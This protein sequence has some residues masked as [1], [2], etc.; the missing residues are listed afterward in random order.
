MFIINRYAGQRI[1]IGGVE[2]KIHRI[3]SDRVW[4]AIP[5]GLDVVKWPPK[6]QDIVDRD[7][8]RIEYGRKRQAP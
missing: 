2:I 1:T 3:Q 5:S 7:D 4:L 6:E 8:H